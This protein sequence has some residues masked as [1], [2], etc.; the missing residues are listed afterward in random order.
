MQTICIIP[1]LPTLSK[2]CM[3]V[4]TLFSVDLAH[5]AYDTIKVEAKR[6]RVDARYGFR[7]DSMHASLRRVVSQS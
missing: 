1:R 3:A 5:L 2:I 4:L 6:L 7:G